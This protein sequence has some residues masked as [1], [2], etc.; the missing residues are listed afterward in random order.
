MDKIGGWKM[1]FKLEPI[2]GRNQMQQIETLRRFTVMPAPGGHPAF[3]PVQSLP[4]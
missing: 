1:M 3:I 4:P 2:A